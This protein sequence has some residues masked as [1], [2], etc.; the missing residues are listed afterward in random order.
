MKH[1]SEDKVNQQDAPCPFSD[2]PTNRYHHSDLPSLMSLL[3][4]IPI[5][6][7]I[8]KFVVKTGPIEMPFIFHQKSACLITLENEDSQ[9]IQTRH[10]YQS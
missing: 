3:R 5:K 6:Q 4:H 10:D 8:G 1:S 9:E 7:R 2:H